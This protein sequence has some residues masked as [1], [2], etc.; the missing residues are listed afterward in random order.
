MATRFR[1]WLNYKEV[2]PQMEVNE[3][4]SMTQ[5]DMTLSIR[6]LLD[7]YA[8]GLPVTLREDGYFEEEDFSEFDN[9]DISD[10]DNLKEANQEN[11]N[12]LTKEFEEMQKP[13]PKPKVKKEEP[14][15]T[16]PDDFTTTP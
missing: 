14:D 15:D 4:E 1:T 12:R 5:P 11:V 9:L 13:K 10:I 3:G 6:E 8:R 2:E 7:R 16:P